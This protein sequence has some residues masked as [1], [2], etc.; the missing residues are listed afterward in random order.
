MKEINNN[1][2]IQKLSFEQIP[3]DKTEDFKDT[4]S[5]LQDNM[6]KRCELEVPEYGD[7]ARVK[8]TLANNDEKIYAGDVSLI[9][10]PAEDNPKKRYLM[11]NQQN[12][13]NRKGLSCLVASGE[14]QDIIDALKDKD[15]VN[16]LKL[17]SDRMSEKMQDMKW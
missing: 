13:Q 9:C 10:E 17:D 4:L 6:L 12:P 15:F 7:F 11:Y 1:T 14:K 8:E 3:Q 16:S 2:N 5:T